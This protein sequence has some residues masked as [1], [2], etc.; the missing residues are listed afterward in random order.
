VGKCDKTDDFLHIFRLDNICKTHGT[1]RPNLQSYQVFRRPPSDQRWGFEPVVDICSKHGFRLQSAV[2]L[3][4][5][6]IHDPWAA[7]CASD[8]PWR[9]PSISVQTSAL[10]ALEKRVEPETATYN[11]LPI[12]AK[13]IFWVLLDVSLRRQK[14]KYQNE[15][16]A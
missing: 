14:S 7:Y 16:Y 1:A 13:K 15:K 6:R 5:T 4:I 11:P 9:S 2:L 8:Q 10:D 12:A 3:T